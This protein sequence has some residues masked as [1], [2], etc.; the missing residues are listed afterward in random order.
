[1]DIRKEESWGKC[2]RFGGYATDISCSADNSYANENS[3]LIR[4]L[5]R[6]QSP[7]SGMITDLHQNVLLSP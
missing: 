7:E 6:T 1:M 3:Y 4:S 2:G 5:G